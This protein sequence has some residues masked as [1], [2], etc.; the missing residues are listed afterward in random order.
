[1]QVMLS[2]DEYEKRQKR[3]EVEEKDLT[4]DISF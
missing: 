2:L 4:K 1:M 3:R